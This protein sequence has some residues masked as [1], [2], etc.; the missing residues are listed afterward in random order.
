MIIATVVFRLHAPLGTQPERE[1]NGRQEHSVKAAEQLHLSVAEIDEQDTHQ[2]I[3][4][5]AAAIVPNKAAADSLM[6][7][8]SVF[9]E[10]NTEAE[11]IDETREIR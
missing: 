2:I 7:E 1:E 3:V 4:I 9:V 11:I 8:I 10:E 6:N 5:G